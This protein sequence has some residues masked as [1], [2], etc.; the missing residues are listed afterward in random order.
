M[1]HFP[2]PSFFYQVHLSSEEKNLL[3]HLFLS[4]LFQEWF[5]NINNIVFFQKCLRKSFQAFKIF[6]QSTLWIAV[7]LPSPLYFPFAK[8]QVQLSYKCLT[9]YLGVDDCLDGSC[10]VF[11][12]FRKSNDVL[13]SKDFWISEIIKVSNTEW[14]VSIFRINLVRMFPYSNWIRSVCLH[15][16]SKCG[17]I[18]TR[19][20]SNMDT[21]YTV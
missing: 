19:I 1:V 10:E 4:V 21:F 14:K 9:G 12:L 5:L 6:F 15:I 20:T 16:Q 11:K 18:Q 2:G 8:L 7:F 17:K 13:H 3:F